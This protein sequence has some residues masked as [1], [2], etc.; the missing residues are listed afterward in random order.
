LPADEI[1]RQARINP[2]FLKGVLEQSRNFTLAEFPG[3]FAM[4]HETDLELKSGGRQQTLLE[5][6]VFSICTGR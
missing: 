1:G 6:L 5:M 4:L 3:I 2:Y